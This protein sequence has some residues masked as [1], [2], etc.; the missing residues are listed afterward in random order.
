V[1]Q[2]PNIGSLAGKWTYR[3]FVN[4]PDLSVAFDALEFGRATLA[5]AEAPMGILQGTIGGTGW[6]LTLNGSINYGDPYSL[7]FQGKGKVGSEEWVYDYAGYVIKPWPDGVNQTPAIVGSI[8]RTA[9]HSSG[10]GG[11]SPAGV[12]CSWIAV[13]QGPLS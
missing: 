3:S 4:N 8:V 6:S 5:I 12:V 1:S 10:S 7:R 13:W 9:P 2:T 11:V